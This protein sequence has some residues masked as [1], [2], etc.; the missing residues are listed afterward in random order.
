MRIQQYG[1]IVFMTVLAFACNRKTVSLQYT[2]AKGEVASL[3]N[4]TFQFDK[5]LV[6]DS[7]LGQW[8]STEYITFE[9]KIPGRFRWE[10]SGELVFSPSQPLSPATDYKATLNDALLRHTGYGRIS[11]GEDLKFHTPSLHLQDVNALWM[12]QDGSPHQAQPQLDLYFNY[13]VNPGTLKERLHVTVDG[14]T[15]DYD[16]QTVSVSDRITIKLP[17]VKAEDKDYKLDISIDKGLVPDGGTNGTSEALT[18]T[19]G[20]PSPFVLTV[21]DATTDHDG[22]TGTITVKTSQLVDGANLAS[23]I[24][25]QPAVKF[26]VTPTDDG[27]TITSDQFDAETSYVLTIN[28]GLRGN[29]GGVLREDYLDNVSFGKMQPSISFNES[30]AVYLSGRGEKNI[31]VRIVSV[32]KIKVVV[33]KVYEN[34]LLMAGAYGYSPKESDGT[35]SSDEEG[36]YETSND[37]TQLGDVIYEKEID[38]KTLPKSGNSR[39]FHFDVDDRLPEFKGVYH[40][41]IHSMEDNWVRDSRFISLSDIGMIAKEG[42]DKILVFTNSIKDATPLAGVNVV[43]YG[44]NN[45]VLGMGS[46]NASGVAE[47]ACTRKEFAGF[48]P[49]MII[50]KTAGDFNYLPFN[51]TRV[52]TSRFEVGGKNSNPTGLDAFI[53]PERDIYRPGE[54]AHFGVMVRTTGWQLPGDLPLK[55]KFLMPNGKELKT[56]RKSLDEQG[57]LD[58]SIDIPQAAVT[59]SY[60][61]EVYT[62]ADVLLGTCT[63]RVEEFVPDRIKVSAKLDAD[64]LTPGQTAHLDIGAQNFFGPPAADRNYECE[65]QIQQQSFSP[66]AFDRYN[67]GLANQNT[68]FDKVERE[69]KTDA[70]GKAREAFDV[71]EMYKGIGEL[72]AVFY[73]TVFDETGRPVSRMASA[74]I[75]TQPIFFGVKDDGYDFYQLNQAVVFPLIAL[76]EKEQVV[77]GTAKVE[78]IKHEYRTVLSKSGDY[79]RYESQKEDRVVAS[80]DMTITGEQTNFSFVPKTPGEYE[81]RVTAPGSNSYVRKAFYSYGGWGADENSFEVNR[82]GQVDIEPDKTSYN[83]GETAKVLFK[84]PFS[85]KMLVTMENADK[86]VSYQYVDV[87]GRSVSLDLPVNRDDLPNVYVTA[88]L[89]K[90]HGVTD[91]PLTVA[92]GFKGLIVEEKSRRMGVEI[93]APAQVRSGIHQTIKVKAAPNSE[94]TLAAVDNG[95]LQVTDFKTP[96]PYRYFYAPRA[97]EVGA[98]DMY[99]LLFPEVL[100]RLSSTG[101]DEGAEM[102]KRVNPMPNKRFKLV[103]YWSGVQKTDGS[104]E[105]TFSFDIPPAFS[106]EV[107][108]MAASCN[109]SSFGAKEAAVKVADPIVLSTALPRFLSPGDTVTMPV[110]ITNTTSRSGDATATV[111]VD[112][113]LKVIGGAHQQ[114]SLGAGS[115]QR[116]VFTVAADRAIAAGKVRV[117]VQGLGE[118]FTDETDITVRP[119]STLQKMSGSGSLSPGSHPVSIGTGD[120]IPG[121]GDYRLVLSRSPAI[122]LGNQLQYLVEYPYGC[123]EQTVSIA[124]PQLYYEDLAGLMNLHGAA[125]YTNAAGNVSEAIRKIKMRQLYNGAITLWD[126]QDKEDWWAT[127]YAAHFL[128]EAQKAGFDIDKSLI[129]SVLSYLNSRLRNKSLVEFWYNRDQH[130]KIAPEEVAYSLYVLA[131]AGRPNASAM[132]YYK[133]NTALLDLQSRY[134]LSAAYA[135]AGDRAAFQTLLPSAFAG[136]IPLAETGGSFSSDIRNES[137]SLNVLLDV[138]PHNPQVAVMARQVAD[139]LKNRPWYSTQE[140]AF[141]FLAMGKLARA[142]AQSTATATARVEGRTIGSMT[143]ASVKWSAAQLKGTQVSLDVT[144]NGALYYWWQ[145]EGISASGAYKEE[146]NYIRARRKFFDRFGHE[147]TGNTFHQ[148]DLVIVQLSLEKSYSGGIDNIVLTDLLPAGFEIE[149]PRTKDIPGMDWIKNAS[150]PTAMDVR[151]DRINLFVD[152]YSD[153]QVYYYAVRAVSPGIYHM[154]PVSA[155]A[156]YNGDYHSYNGAGTIRVVQ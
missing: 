19:T 100:A 12:A 137:V 142:A 55:M 90:P 1:V 28:H 47:I 127:V 69:G 108:L 57:A 111:M 140:C 17:N 114:V 14:R 156:M 109:G 85:G 82:E 144:G 64:A 103:S 115:E 41:M 39:V 8:D 92:H 72:R 42:K 52:N 150:E 101:G 11:G 152:L 139:L 118:K 119:A 125:R 3:G 51:S 70:Q 65:I 13:P 58:G 35:Q 24:H 128:L 121:S 40:L 99:P 48:A 29:I 16:L 130:K 54:Q 50:A 126:G 22:A 112:G 79:F 134:L 94:V 21:N 32:G 2:N 129:E 27:F 7:L 87:P 38:T 136:E 116:V 71:P 62:S 131:L 44:K 59:G 138:D 84:T 53:Y 148:N 143:G 155:D 74:N 98:Y 4:L 151:D 15:A 147:I 20:V 30:K 23:F 146:D 33:S 106:G 107:R 76:N 110:T 66:R 67:F 135:M 93:D 86:V 46:T 56:F 81:L 63:F 73:A 6:K 149:N 154:G 43:A 25:L 49:A 45:Q 9:P 132:N 96:D 91:I 145:A 123:T 77:T 34:N 68:F 5:D 75:Y 83:I 141:G 36:E 102:E 97:L 104:G 10:N 124:F 95:I 80:R 120:F 37:E 133:A 113:P 60:T 153:R 117:L 88:T 26:E 89:F 61:L 122:Q 18:Y 78:V 105:A 31:A